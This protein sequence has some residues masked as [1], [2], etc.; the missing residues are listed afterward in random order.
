MG[1]RATLILLLSSIVCAS[2][3]FDASQCPTS[4]STVAV[5]V[6]ADP[7]PAAE[8]VVC[9]GRRYWADGGM[10]RTWEQARALCRSMGG[11]LASIH[12]ETDVACAVQVVAPSGNIPHGAWIGL[13]EAQVEGAWR[14]S[15]GTPVNFVHWLAGEPN[16]DS[17]GPNDCGH[18]WR[19][20]DFQWNDLPCTRTDVSFLC[21]LP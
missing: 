19:E 6:R 14:W 8:G 21:E 9:G 10:G 17:G 3:C 20:H 11:D 1:N 18:M 16:N 5:A 2:G 7:P 12:D 4:K 13:Y 15:D